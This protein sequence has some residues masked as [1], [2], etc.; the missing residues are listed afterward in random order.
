MQLLT[1][2]TCR[3]LESLNKDNTCKNHSIVPGTE[4]EFTKRSHGLFVDIE[5]ECEEGKKEVLWTKRG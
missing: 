5:L 4:W 2:Q 1:V 3:M